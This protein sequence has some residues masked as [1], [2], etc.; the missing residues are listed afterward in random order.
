[1]TIARLI[2]KKPYENRI[3][4]LRRHWLTMVKRVGAYVILAA[5]PFGIYFFLTENFPEMLRSSAGYPALVLAFSAYELGMWLFLFTMFLD[6]ELDMW[7]VTNDRLVNIEQHGL[8]ARTIAELD[9]WRVQ[10]VTSDV[11]GVFPTFFDYGTVYVQT[12]GAT[13]R[14][15]L[16]QVPQPHEVRKII[17]D[18]ADLDRKF[19]ERDIA[20]IQKIATTA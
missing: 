17:L 12:A 20:E 15:A 14:F 16:E 10:D 6:Y 1:M 7:V 5:I 4:A 9:L 13:E 11:R 18:M 3:I 2:A 8:F 19:H